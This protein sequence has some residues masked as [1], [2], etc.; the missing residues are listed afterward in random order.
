MR[1][2]DSVFADPDNF[3]AV[4]ETLYELRAAS[5]SRIGPFVNQWHSV[6]AEFCDSGEFGNLGVSQFQQ[7]PRPFDLGVRM[8]AEQGGFVASEGLIFDR[9]I[10]R[11]IS[12]VRHWVHREFSPDDL[13]YL[14]R[15]AE[16]ARGCDVFTLNY[17]STIER[18][19]AIVTVPITTGFVQT[20]CHYPFPPHR[21]YRGLWSAESIESNESALRLSKLHGS[22]HWFVFQ[23]AEIEPHISEVW[24]ESLTADQAKDIESIHDY[25]TW[26]GQRPSPILFAGTGKLPAHE[27]Y[28][29]LYRRLINCVQSADVLVTIGCRWQVEPIV[30]DVIKAAVMR[31]PDPLPVLEVTNGN[32]ADTPQ[33]L[34]G[35][36]RD[37]ILSGRLE[38]ATQELVAQRAKMRKFQETIQATKL[39]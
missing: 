26:R 16:L 34:Y 25:R 11:I 12:G 3:E 4:V 36:A 30:G 19:S 38:H 27:P 10:Q 37:A 24:L 32:E 23:S 18:A 22:I 2:S 29:T 8:A 33:C 6:L 5:S 21:I 15:L 31:Q 17:D 14:S 7:F 28:L 9:L 35:G 13:R 39:P 20:K 1:E